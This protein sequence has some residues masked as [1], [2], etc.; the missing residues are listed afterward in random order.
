MFPLKRLVIMAIM[1]SFLFM[2][3]GAM[4]QE[5]GPYQQ[6]TNAQQPTTVTS[7]YITADIFAARPVGLVSTVFGTVT[8][9]LASPFSALGGN[10]SHS[11]D[12]LVKKPFFYTFD[13]PI[14]VF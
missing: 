10:F 7:G 6:S 5:K 9:V 1:A 14:G 12:E 3:L 4:A 8:F 2:P 13:R 11:F